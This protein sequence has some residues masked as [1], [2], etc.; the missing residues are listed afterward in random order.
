MFFQITGGRLHPDVA[1]FEE[2]MPE[3]EMEQAMEASMHCLAQQAS[4]C[5]NCWRV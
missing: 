4:S 2:P 1:W 5:R 3:A